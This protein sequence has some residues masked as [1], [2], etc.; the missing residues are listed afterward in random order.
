MPKTIRKKSNNKNKTKKCPIGLKPFMNKDITKDELE[1]QFIKELLSKFS[2]GSIRP[3]D[4]FYDYINY[5]WL[6]NITLKE[7]QK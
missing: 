4:D 6:Q 5:Q 7:Q 1:K 3:E 2:P